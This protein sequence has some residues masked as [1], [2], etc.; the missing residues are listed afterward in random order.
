MQLVNSGFNILKVNGLTH[1][2]NWSMWKKS[3]ICLSINVATLTLG[4]WLSVE[5]KGT[6]GQNNVFRSETHFHKWGGL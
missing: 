4:S 5:S 2:D 6:W 1:V 3:L